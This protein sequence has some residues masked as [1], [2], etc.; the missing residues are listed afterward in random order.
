[1]K[2]H[3]Y[4]H[5]ITIE[6]LSLSLDTLSLS[7]DERQHLLSLVEENLHFTIVDTVLSQLD[8]SDK[9]T[10]LK[11]LQHADNHEKLW[12]FL[13]SKK[14]AIGHKIRQKAQDLINELHKD[15]KDAKGS[16]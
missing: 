8:E 3:F 4:S 13:L 2:K 11:R 5:L 12:E 9:K 7:K 15:I 6:S 10:F 16:R 14:K 1:M